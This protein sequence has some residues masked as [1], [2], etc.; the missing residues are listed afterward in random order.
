M[1]KRFICSLLLSLFLLAGAAFA[2]KVAP[3]SD[4][5]ADRAELVIRIKDVQAPQLK[6]DYVIFTADS[7]SRFVGIA[8]DFEN[9][10]I[11]HP[12]QI[13]K[14]YDADGEVTK[15]F[16][17]YILKLDKSM[18]DI[19]YRVVV[20]GLWTLDPTNTEKKYDRAT[21][22]MLS[23]FDANR[24]IPPATEV[25]KDGIVRFVYQGEAKQQVRLGGSFT[26]WDS[27]I[28]E[29]K[30]VKP[31]LYEFDLPLPPGTYQYAFFTGVNMMVDR[32]NPQ[33]CYSPDGKVASQLTVAQKK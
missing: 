32:S 27:W 12:Y 25:Q 15:S 13:R 30:E 23:Y 4:E 18:T 29:M 14:I 5:E 2:E 1:E 17:F 3:V 33:R 21:G 31:G 22:L 16:F 7:D 10:H 6:G 9:F 24:D 26:N 8:F 11:I 19:R 28:Y 20:D